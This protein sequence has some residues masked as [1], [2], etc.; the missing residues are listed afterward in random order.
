MVGITIALVQTAAFCIR[1]SLFEAVCDRTP[2]HSH[3]NVADSWYL[4]IYRGQSSSAACTSP[5]SHEFGPRPR[6]R[7]FGTT[8]IHN[9]SSYSVL[10]PGAMR[11][12]AM[13]SD[14]FGPH[15]A[16]VP[17]YPVFACLQHRGADSRSC[18]RNAVTLSRLKRTSY[19]SQILPDATAAVFNA[20]SR[21]SPIHD[22]CTPSHAE[23]QPT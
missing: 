21:D 19:S 8:C 18:I 2:M 20:S 5:C 17:L 4:R 7:P 11:T 16:R 15:A 23:G 13:G 1:S 3:S 14:A 22:T 12:A 9:A 6:Y 10:S